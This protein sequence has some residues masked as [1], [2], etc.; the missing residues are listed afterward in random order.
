MASGRR[1]QRGVERRQPSPRRVGGCGG[2]G[3]L[4]TQA[5]ELEEERRGRQ[6]LAGLADASDVDGQAFGY[7][8]RLIGG[9]VRT[10]TT[11]AGDEEAMKKPYSSF[12]C[13]QKG[14]ES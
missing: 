2:S 14:G 9:F 10:G 3:E 4:D 8:P 12:L 13:G 7:R 11:G 1:T 6:S 5:V